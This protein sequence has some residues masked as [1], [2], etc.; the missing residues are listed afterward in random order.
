MKGW[1]E[2]RAEDMKRQGKIRGW[3][4]NG[5]KHQSPNGSIVAKHFHRCSKEK[6]WMGW[7]LL[8]WSNEHAVQL[9]EEYQ[10]D[11]NG[12]KWRADWAIPSLKIIVE[13]EGLMSDKSRHTTLL[14]FS[15]DTRKYAEASKQDWIV[16]RYTIITYRQVINDLN[17]VIAK[18]I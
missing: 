1:N 9:L 16:L 15:G 18:K 6:D 7:N 12:R 14:G 3:K 2:Q 4:A 10:F 13:F 8:Y 17:D 5:P 11:L